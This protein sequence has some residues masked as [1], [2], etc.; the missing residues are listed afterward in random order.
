MLSQSIHIPHVGAAPLCVVHAQKR[1]LVGFPRERDA[2]IV[3][4]HLLSAPSGVAFLPGLETMQLKYD[5]DHV[6]CL[7]KDA[8]LF[9]SK[10]KR[11]RALREVRL[12]TMEEATFINLPF[13]G[14]LGVIIP[15]VLL[16]DSED[17][18]T[19]RCVAIDPVDYT[20]S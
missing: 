14:S 3:K 19:F 9:V 1:Y 12:R 18:L 4:P 10:E 2:R 16:D 20:R 15:T 11:K 6:L 7:D 13:A 8:T 17:E 5:T